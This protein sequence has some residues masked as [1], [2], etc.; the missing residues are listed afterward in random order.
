MLEERSRGARIETGRL[1]VDLM[2]ARPWRGLARRIPPRRGF[3]VRPVDVVCAI[4]ECLLIGCGI[5]GAV[6]SIILGFRVHD[7]VAEQATVQNLDRT[8]TPAVVTERALKLD[9]DAGTSYPVTVAVRWTGPDGLEHGGTA[10]L[11]GQVAAGDRV[12]VWL[13]R[14]GTPVPA[15]TRASDAPLAGW[16]TWFFAFVGVCGILVVCWMGVRRWGLARACAAWER[17]WTAIG[18]TWTRRPETR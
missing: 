8:A 10:E 6:F 7:A 15:P 18:P 12:T 14:S 9:P 11:R 3:P 5:A 17:E 13:D 16:L 2:P 4:A 1:E